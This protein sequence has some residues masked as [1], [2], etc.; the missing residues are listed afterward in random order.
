MFEAILED[1]LFQAVFVVSTTGIC[2][3]L[4]GWALNAFL[5][6]VRPIRVRGEGYDYVI[7]RVFLLD[8]PGSKLA[9][10]GCCLIG[11]LPAIA[12]TFFIWGWWLWE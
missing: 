1:E 10:L 2:L 9:W 6:L 3:I 4:L 12:A 5:N 11:T 7:P 8:G